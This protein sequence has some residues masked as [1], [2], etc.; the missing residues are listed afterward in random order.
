MERNPPTGL[1]E[2]QLTELAAAALDGAGDL[3]GFLDSTGRVRYANRAACDEVQISRELV[4]QGA[5]FDFLPALTPELWAQRWLELRAGG[6]LRFADRMRQRDGTTFLVDVQASLVTSDG[7]E[8]AL[9]VAR[10]V[11][12][13]RRAERALRESA[14][15]FRALTENN[16]AL[17][18]R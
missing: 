16:P 17:V 2:G 4:L 5:I 7:M 11:T 1:P 9:V 12:E 14:E 13:A 10:D 3:I 15:A 18:T 8:F 6:R